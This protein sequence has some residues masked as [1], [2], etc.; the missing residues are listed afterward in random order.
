MLELRHLSKTYGNGTA[1]LQD[2]TLTV[3]SGEAVAIVGGSGCGKSTLLRLIA[4]LEQPTL[5]EARVDGERI[6]EP[7]PAVGLVFQEP[8]LLPWLN[9]GDNVAFGI[10]GVPDGERKSR[11]AAVL[12]SVGLGE[13]AGKWPR[14]M[15]GGMAQ[16][17]AL[18]RALVTRPSVLLLDE[19]FS[20][21]DA[22]T[23]AG[24]QDHLV[25]L[26]EKS[27]PTLVLVT[28][29][30]EEALV[31]ANRVIVL[32]P[33]P[34]RIDAVIDVRLPRPRNRD[35]DDFEAVKRELR[36]ALDRSLRYP[37]RADAAE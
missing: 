22:L 5:G 19:P 11:V 16:R 1:A 27:R 3:D 32:R 7:H 13:H 26:W 6:C 18:A 8:R 4:G 35:A 36:A 24:L 29:D 31:V 28:H 9:V 2:F 33:K 37:L 30:I 12:D 15:S 10:E 21:L 20:A 17:V 34:G 14:E 25:E 23:R